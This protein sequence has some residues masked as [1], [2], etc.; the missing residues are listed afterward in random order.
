[1]EGRSRVRLHTGL[2]D[3]CEL[4]AAVW[5]Y[6]DERLAAALVD[7]SLAADAHGC[8]ADA[9]A[10]PETLDRVDRAFAGFDDVDAHELWERL[11]LEHSRLFLI[12]VGRPNVYIYEGPF[13]HVR[14]GRE[15]EPGLFGTITVHAVKDIMRASG[16]IPADA[17]VEPVDSVWNEFSFLSFLYGSL[18]RDELAQLND[19]A[20]GDPDADGP[21]PQEWS[22]RIRGFW[23]AHPST[24]LPSFMDEVVSSVDKLGLGPTYAA[25]ALLGK[26]TIAR[27]AADLGGGSETTV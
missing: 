14:A 18:A 4:M 2:A 11:R 12:A 16:V 6:P 13:K 27:I 1:M 22:A 25:F 19:A 21:A 15:G 17:D 23:D 26:E 24:W 20:D 8:L 9:G 5:Q 10:D 7:G 3:I